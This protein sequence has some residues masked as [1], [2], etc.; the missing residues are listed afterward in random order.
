MKNKLLFLFIITFATKQVLCQTSFKYVTAKAIFQLP[1][2][3]KPEIISQ[4]LFYISPS[5]LIRPDFYCNNLGFICK[6]EIKIQKAIRLPFVFRI[7][8]LQQVDYLEGKKN[9]YYYNK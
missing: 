4:N 8:S 2:Y 5:M 6:Q 3:I 1:K 9:S 7:G